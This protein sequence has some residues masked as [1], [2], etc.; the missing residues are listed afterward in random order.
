MLVST[1][2]VPGRHTILPGALRLIRQTYFLPSWSL[3]SSRRKDVEQTFIY[4]L[5]QV[6][7]SRSVFP[8]INVEIEAQRCDPSCLILQVHSVKKTASQVV[9]FFTMEVVKNLPANTGD[10]RD[11]GLIP[12]SGNHPQRRKLQTTP[13]FLP[14][15]SHGQRRLASYSPRGCKE[16]DTIKHARMLQIKGNFMPS[17]F[18]TLILISSHLPQNLFCY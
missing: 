13:V 12:G 4:P 18:Q 7:R 17:S 14:G 11:A 6:L 9:P 16:S 8:F 3:Q 2:Y 10:T 15:K 5:L 1:F